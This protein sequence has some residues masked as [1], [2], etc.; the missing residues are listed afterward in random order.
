MRICK[1]RPPNA[2]RKGHSPCPR[3]Q[4]ETMGL[5]ILLNTIINVTTKIKL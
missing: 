3:P 4:K 2:K 5:Y 1:I